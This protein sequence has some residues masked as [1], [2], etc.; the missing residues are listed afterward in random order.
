MSA[1]S[2]PKWT[3]PLKVVAIAMAAFGFVYGYVGAAGAPFCGSLGMCLQLAVDRGIA[4]FDAAALLPGAVAAALF[5]AFVYLL[6]LP[7]YWVRKALGRPSTEQGPAAADES[8][9]PT[10]RGTLPPRARPPRLALALGLATLWAVLSV[11]PGRLVDDVGRLVPKEVTA[12]PWCAADLASGVACR[13]T[14]LP[15][16]VAPGLDPACGYIQIAVPNI[17]APG[18]VEADGLCHARYDGT[19]DDLLADVLAG[20]SNGVLAFI[21]LGAALLIWPRLQKTGTPGA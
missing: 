11:G 17:V 10:P 8:V 15:L 1:V 20:I 7:V 18:V 6:Y 21:A 14:D 19:A 2:L 5:G 4:G 13:Q 9:A 3:K 12:T 16:L